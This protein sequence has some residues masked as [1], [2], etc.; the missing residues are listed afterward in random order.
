MRLDL[1]P[2]DRLPSERPF[3][4]EGE[5]EAITVGGEAVE[6]S[7][8]VTAQ[9]RVER[10]RG[11]ARL[12]GEVVAPVRLRCGR[13]LD[14][15]ETTLRGPLEVMLDGPG[16]ESDEDSVPYAEH[17]DL[18]PAV[19]EAIVLELPVRAL[20]RPDCQ[21]LCPQC[22]ARREDGCDCEPDGDPRLG[23]LAEWVKSHPGDGDHDR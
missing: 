8:P 5:F 9:G 22:G 20:C 2:L 4:V 15:F 3:A 12:T 13:C 6:F 18:T 19:E 16:N 23:V 17:L 10:V 1:G 21:G 14:R 11:G 7:A